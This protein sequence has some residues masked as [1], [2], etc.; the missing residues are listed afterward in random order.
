MLIYYWLDNN[1][2][3]ELLISLF[4]LIKCYH[5][6]NF[7]LKLNKFL[8]AAIVPNTIASASV[9]LLLINEEY[10]T[11]EIMAIVLHKAFEHVNCTELK[12]MKIS[13]RKII[14]ETLLFKMS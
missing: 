3:V 8:T 13:I 10:R 4:I 11:S 9:N 14:Q 5:N 7:K 1:R 12:L 6:L 2:E